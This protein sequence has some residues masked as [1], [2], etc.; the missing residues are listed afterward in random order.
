MRSRWV[1]MA[2]WV[3]VLLIPIASA[4]ASNGSGF[5]FPFI[6]SLAILVAPAIWIFS[7]K[8]KLKTAAGIVWAVVL[9]LT[10]YL[11]FQY[12]LATLIF[13]GIYLAIRRVI[14]NYRA[15]RS[16]HSGE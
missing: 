4:D 10:I 16:D 15:N 1:V 5:R 2:I 8:D 11:W 14:R 9:V 13:A 12:L 7:K 6:A 3:V